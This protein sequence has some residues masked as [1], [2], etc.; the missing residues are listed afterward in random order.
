MHC[1]RTKKNKPAKHSSVLQNNNPLI[2]FAIVRYLSLNNNAAG[3]SLIRT[4]D[5]LMDI[6]KVTGCMSS[7]RWMCGVW[8]NERKGESKRESEKN[9]TWKCSY[10]AFILFGRS[11]A[12]FS[13]LFFNAHQK[14]HKSPLEIGSLSLTCSFKEH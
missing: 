5:S 11:I 7:S 2:S 6:F 8:I 1:G 3:T 13:S 10:S 9:L 14:S 12:V 4:K